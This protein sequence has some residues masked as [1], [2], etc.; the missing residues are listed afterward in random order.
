MVNKLSNIKLAL[1]GVAMMGMVASCGESEFRVD[2]C[3][4]GM[5]EGVVVLERGLNGKWVALDSV[6]TSG[7]G[8][9]ELSY[10]APEYPDV[11]RLRVADRFVYFPI[12]SLEHI[13]LQASLAGFDKDFVLSGSAKAERLMKFEKSLSA[14]DMNDSVAVAQLKRDVY[15]EII[16]DGK[17][18][19]L[20]Y[21]VL[22]KSIDG[23]YLFDPSDKFDSKIY[24]AV[25]T[26]YKQF[27][28]EDP[29]AALLEA[30]AMESRRLVNTLSGRQRV[31][32][33]NEISMI[34]IDLKDCAGKSRTL[35]GV[36]K[37]GKPTVVV[38]SVLTDEK[39][40]EVNRE[41]ADLYNKNAGR[42]NIYQVCLD[43]DQLAWKRAA[44]NL[45]WVVV[46]DPA[47]AESEYVVKYNVLAIPAAYI[48]NAKGELV[49]Q[50]S[51]FSDLANKMSRY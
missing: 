14:L 40:P 20:S 39:S 4:D 18:D 1:A 51:S 21:Y 23:R 35:S 34:D 48:Y 45:P 44:E 15:N 27:R 3:I 36:L 38:F 43:Y 37:E 30:M 28:P 8:E 26:A 25:A 42:I 16:K 33:A 9:F 12:D 22:N 31:V 11:Y 41:L 7:K 6:E 5:S 19:V 24:A 49:D 2:G 50:A 17:A 46:Y 13:H 32:E 47:G 10:D 29:R